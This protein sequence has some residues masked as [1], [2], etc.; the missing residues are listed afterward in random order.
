MHHTISSAGHL[1]AQ[2]PHFFGFDVRNSLVV[3]TTSSTTHALGPLLRLDVPSS[4]KTDETRQTL[5]TALRRLTDRE[6]GE[7]V[8]ILISS[9]WTAQGAAQADALDEVCEEVAYSVGFVIKDFY[10][11]PHCQPNGEW[12]SLYTGETGTIPRIAPIDMVTTGLRCP[13]QPSQLRNEG[14]LSG[15]PSVADIAECPVAQSPYEPECEEPNYPEEQPALMSRDETQ[16]EVAARATDLSHLAQWEV[17]AASL[18]FR[19]NPSGE[20]LRR[21]LHTAPTQSVHDQSAVVMRQFF[22]RSIES[23]QGADGLIALL[24]DRAADKWAAWLWELLPSFDL[25]MRPYVLLT[26]AMWYYM[27]G[28]G[29]RA[30]TML[31]QASVIDP[32]CV[33]TRT[34]RQLLNMCIEPKELRKVVDEIAESL[35]AEGA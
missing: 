21:I 32:Q 11:A 16:K 35:W 19:S 23:C 14:P 12:V 24:A 15:N 9:D 4:G 17:R 8:I 27:H 30:H 31:D 6:F 33:E 34:L 25:A 1:I 26:L 3:M 18:A 10:M 28:D 20:E 13:E 7:L 2:V 29:F 5:T 22:L